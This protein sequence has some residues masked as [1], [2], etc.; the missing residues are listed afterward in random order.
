MQA[1]KEVY[2]PSALNDNICN[3]STGLLKSR[4]QDR[5]RAPEM[6]EYFSRQNTPKGCSGKDLEKI[7]HDQPILWSQRNS[8]IHPYGG[9]G[10]NAKYGRGPETEH[11]I[12]RAWAA[13]IPAK[14]LSLPFIKNILNGCRK[15]QKCFAEYAGNGS[16][17]VGCGGKLYHGT[18]LF[19]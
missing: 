8:E 18:Q 13:H 2:H 15:T 11:R 16:L 12:A 9:L 5:G 7:P 1:H 6:Q 4:M 14:D 19:F 3:Q 10:Y 17:Q